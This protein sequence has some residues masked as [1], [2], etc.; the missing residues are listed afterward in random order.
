MSTPKFEDSLSLKVSF[1]PRGNVPP[2][3]LARQQLQS[4]LV[5]QQSELAIL[6]RTIDYELRNIAIITN[7]IPQLQTNKQ[8][9]S[10]ALTISRQGLNAITTNKE[11]MKR[12]AY[13][14][15]DITMGH[16]S[17]HSNNANDLIEAASLEQLQYLEQQKDKLEINISQSASSLSTLES[18]LHGM[19]VTLAVSRTSLNSYLKRSE[20]T[21][22][23]IQELRSQLSPVKRVP[24]EIWHEIFRICIEP[25]AIKERQAQLII[26]THVCREWRAIVLRSSGLGFLPYRHRTRVVVS[27]KTGTAQIVSSVAMLCGALTAFLFLY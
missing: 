6:E 8:N 23:M 13:C 22:Y 12:M 24:S 18:E 4:R 20:E 17:T 7:G 3:S 21:L 25:A 10:T 1:R 9:I 26:I 5:H 19:H 16:K 11:T 15:G 27:H 14:S 2:S